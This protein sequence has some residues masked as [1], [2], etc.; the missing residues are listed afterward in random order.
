MVFS[1][2]DH[3]PHGRK[4]TKTQ[5]EK[6]VQAF[7]K[8][9]PRS[10]AIFQKARRYTPFGVHSNYRFT[11]PYPLYCSGGKGSRIWD[12]DGNEYID[13]CMGFG[14]LAT[15]HA[16]PALVEAV[17][18]RIQ[19]GT[20]LGFEGDDS[21]R[22]GKTICDRFNLDMVRFSSTGLEGTL[23]AVRLARAHTGRPLI[24]KF[25]GCYHG[26]HDGLLVSVK[27]SATKS[28]T[29]K[30]PNAVP[31]S[32][33]IPPEVVQ[34]TIVAQFND[35]AG[36]EELMSKKGDRVAAIILEPIP[37]NMGFVVPME[38]FLEGLRKLCTSNGS[39]LIFDE[40]KTSGKFY[41]GA[42]P[43]FGVTPDLKVLGKA[44][45]GGYPLSCVG[46]R[47]EIMEKIVPAGTFNSNPLSVA[48][49][50]AT[51]EKVLTRGSMARASRLGDE[52]GK[53]CRD[54]ISDHGLEAKVQW[55]GLSGTVHFTS[56][57]VHNWR[58]FLKCNLGRWWTYYLSM[59][60]RG[61]IPM[62]TGPDEQWTVSVQHREEDIARHL[63][64]FGAVARRLR[65]AGFHLPM[66][67]AV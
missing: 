65:E 54:L 60:N 9:T 62:A 53:G 6:E 46:G 42:Q 21:V 12:V 11:D 23:H 33:G 39:V 8:R 57:E 26:S 61:V 30:L 41:N 3:R 67:E 34:D 59:L 64:V 52:L 45:A 51:L 50:R 40:V 25:E 27:P 10:A 16:H 20:L 29:K 48:A 49:A 17:S 37:M 38:G 22:L 66:V 24:L 18:R 7:K 43:R 28:G 36:V 4:V 1:G 55:D 19:E 44:I 56:R 47:K 35:L 58:D 14:A 31:A 63:E 15:G 32:L 13:F 2:S 5:A